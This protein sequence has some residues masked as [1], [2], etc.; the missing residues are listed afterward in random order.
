MTHGPLYRAR[1]LHLK[2]RFQTAADDSKGALELYFVARPSADA[3]KGIE[4]Q[5]I[6]E[7]FKK[8]Y[9]NHISSLQGAER[10]EAIE[11]GKRLAVGLAQFEMSS[12]LLGKSDASYWAGLTCFESGDYDSAIDWI[13]VR[14]LADPSLM[15]CP[16]LTGGHYNLARCLEAK[17][18]RKGAILAYQDSIFDSLSF[19]NK[20]RAVWLKQL[21]EKK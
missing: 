8:W 20:V 17:G 16:W 3:L 21:D 14:T 2:G 5:T 11:Q 15:T 1:I 6:E 19:G 9:E 4:R 10:A 7:D 12:L 13:Q 18:N